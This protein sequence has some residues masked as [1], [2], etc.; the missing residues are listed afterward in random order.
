MLCVWFFDP[1]IAH[2]GFSFTG[3]LSTGAGPNG[4]CTR[5][6]QT[7][8]R[9]VM[10]KSL[11]C[12]GRR[13]NWQGPRWWMRGDRR[14]AMNG[15]ARRARSRP[16]GAATAA[17]DC[18]STSGAHRL[19]KRFSAGLSG[20][21]SY[22]WGKALTDAVDHLSTSGAGDG[23][24]VGVFKEAQ[25]GYH[26]RAE[27]GLSEFDVQHRFVAS[28]VWQIPYGRGRHFGGTASH[29]TDLVLGGWELSP[30]IT[31]QGGLGLTI[32]QPNLLNL[33]GER[34]SR[35]NRLRNGA[36][37]DSQRTV[38]RYFDTDAFQ[39]LE[40]ELGRPGFVPN[41]AF[42]N[43]G[44]GILRGPGLASVDFNLSK[45]FHLTEKQ[46]VQFRAEFFNALNHPN[47][48]V[49]GVNI[50]GG[51]GQIVSTATEARIIQFA[52]KYRF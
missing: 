23:V 45:S 34:Q 17:P 32:I 29:G 33:G 52:L 4:A 40:I 13:G 14:K 50:G 26:R 48:G 16:T 2:G 24:D 25:D 42:G 9:R 22:T 10:P 11:G 47:F 3:G 12:R 5:P 46:S 18:R 6:P 7:A 30:I 51:F 41:Q 38:D 37:P 43:S 28:A 8:R 27:Y 39:R 49:P 20:L 44:V 19:E 21:V 31:V 1:R 36:L 35:P 15:N